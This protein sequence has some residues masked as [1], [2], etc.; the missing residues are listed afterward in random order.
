MHK[1]RLSAALVIF[2]SLGGAAVC[3]YLLYDEIYLN[4]SSAD[5]LSQ[6]GLLKEKQQTVKRKLGEEMLWD[7]IEANDKLYWNDSIQTAQKSEATIHLKDGSEIR[8]GE[9]S[10]VVLERE[11]NK[12][13]LNLKSGQAVIDASKTAD[14]KSDIKVNGMTLAQASNVSLQV[15]EKKGQL[16]ATATSSDGTGKQITVDKQ[17][18]MEEK[19]VPAVLDSPAPLSHKYIDS[20]QAS[21]T[22]T[23][24][25]KAD[26]KTFELAR[27]KD[28][29]QVIFH[30]DTSDNNLRLNLIQ[31]SYFWR[32]KA[33][34]AKGVL[35]SEVR[36]LD[37]SQMQVPELLPVEPKGKV[38]FRTDFPTV[39]FSWKGGAQANKYLFELSASEDFK[40]PI[41]KEETPGSH[42]KT[43]KLNE[44]KL[45]WRV[46]AIY[47]DQVKTSQASHFEVTRLKEV[48]PPDLMFPEKSFSVTFDFFEQSKGIPFR[49]HAEPNETYKF[50]LSRTD[51]LKEEVVSFET[52]Q[53][54]TLVRDNYPA[55]TYYWSVGHKNLDGEWKFK[56]VRKIVLGPLVPLL[57]P[58]VSLG[59]S[60]QAE[61]DLLKNPLVKWRWQQVQGAKE[62]K[63]KLFKISSNSKPDLVL[64]DVLKGNEKQKDDLPD[65]AYK[66]IVSSVDDFGRESKPVE[67]EFS[68]RHGKTLEATDFEMSEVQ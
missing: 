35:T 8:L 68:V 21:V 44:G 36:S 50:V 67:H 18:H 40:N 9:S 4:K 54:D 51:T 53:S 26:K 15:D 37:V 63:F 42:V 12:L 65:G 39:D 34:S 49:W 61:L 1:E 6:A 29:S 22:F 55:G 57:Q 2:I 66:W 7:S 16:T 23:W 19:E 48:Q 13:S 5:G 38:A 47:G 52:T 58:P 60:E 31:G 25:A 30:K 24:Q 43:S 33:P 27:D 32:V 17:G 45:F 64:E 14:K 20:G 41:F 56:E 59:P 62:Y 28:F 3:G 11:D 10:L 46:S